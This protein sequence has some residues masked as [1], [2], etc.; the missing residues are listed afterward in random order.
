MKSILLILQNF[1]FNPKIAFIIFICFITGY[2]IF[3]DEEGS[4]G[5]KFFK[6]GPDE[7]TTFLNMKINTWPKVILLYF[8]G[9]LSTLCISYYNT[10]TF[11]FIHS[12]L[13]NPAYNEPLNVSK[14]WTTIM[15]LVDPIIYWALEIIQFFIN[16]TMRFQFLFPQL[17][18]TLLA[19][20]PYGLYKISQNKFLS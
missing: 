13:W 1:F 10:V 19:Q 16:L 14:L 18:G 3:L 15:I 2:L 11:D 7:D 20:I 6:F 17:L 5:K 9:F 8:L 4:F 12:K